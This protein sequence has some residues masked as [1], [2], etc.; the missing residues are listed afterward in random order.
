M[1]FLYLRAPSASILFLIS[2]QRACIQ[3]WDSSC[4]TKGLH[5]VDLGLGEAAW[6]YGHN[7]LLGGIGLSEAF[8]ESLSCGSGSCALSSSQI[9]AR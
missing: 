1:S 7:V 6:R 2:L 8:N 9:M 3:D 5:G 4:R